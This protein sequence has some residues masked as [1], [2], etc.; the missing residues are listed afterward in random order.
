VDEEVSVE[1]ERFEEK[2]Q[3]EADPYA[4]WGVHDDYDPFAPVAMVGAARPAI[5]PSR[6][7][8]PGSHRAVIVGFLN[9]AAWNW[10]SVPDWVG[11]I[12][13]GPSNSLLASSCSGTNSWIGAPAMLDR[14]C[15]WEDGSSGGYEICIRNAGEAIALK[16]GNVP[17]GPFHECRAVFDSGPF[18]LHPG[19]PT[20]SQVD[21]G[22]GVE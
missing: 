12:G 5:G 19:E 2:S 9:R 17:A 13:Y 14:R 21:L 11:G 3:V 18:W 15:L 7:R 1:E 8:L 16:P 20:Y 4:P 6:A 22:I 10:G